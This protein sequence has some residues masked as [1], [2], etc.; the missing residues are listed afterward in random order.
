MKKYTL[1]FI[2]VAVFSFG[3][4]NYAYADTKIDPSKTGNVNNTTQIDPVQTGQVGNP[5][6]PSEKARKLD[7]PTGGSTTLEG[8]LLRLFDIV[9][10]IGIPVVAFF[11]IYS[12]F[13]FVIAQGRPGEIESAKRRLGW[14]IVG[15]ILLLGA[16][17]IS[18]AI[19]GTI[20]DIK[21]GAVTTQ[22]TKK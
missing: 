16:W 18:Q 6:N 5:I 22:T 4:G 21:K 20:D 19:K 12:G 1:I 13:M 11:L 8:M 2:L 15:A 9:F 17:T 7:D 14:T 10:Y 3:I